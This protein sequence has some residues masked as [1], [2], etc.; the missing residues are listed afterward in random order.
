[1]LSELFAVVAP[2]ALCVAVGFFWCRGGQHFPAEF[3]SAL[4]TR[5]GAPCL[6]VGTL[7]EVKVSPRLLGEVGLAVLLVLLFTAAAG[8]LV[9]RAGGLSV[10][11]MLGPLVFPNTGNMGLP[12]ALFAFGDSGLAIALAVFLLV[13]FAHFTLGVALVSG[14]SPW[15]EALRSPIVWAG[16]IGIALVLLE[17]SLPRWLENSVGLLGDF[18]IPLMLITLGVSL[19][20]LR[21]R[22]LR[23]SVALA[24]ARLAIGVG[25]GVLACGLLE[26]EGVM[27][28]V[29]ILQ[30]AMPVAV[31]NYLLAHR[32]G[33]EPEAVAGT[34]VISTALAFGGLPLLLWWLW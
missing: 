21:V 18:T 17:Q 25:A 11:A 26:L 2:I 31:F 6:I 10:R 34:V 7:T 27:R 20:Q 32:Y 29:V 13:S 4:V 23:R 3:V 24:L 9:C 22:D 5:I 19:A 33:A 14:S 16:A 8:W 28:S 30:S 1:M 12:L 15:R